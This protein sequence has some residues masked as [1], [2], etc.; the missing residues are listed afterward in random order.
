MFWWVGGYCS[1]RLV[2][3]VKPAIENYRRQLCL[4]FQR[5]IKLLLFSV[6]N[7][8]QHDESD[9]QKGNHTSYRKRQ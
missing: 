9:D 5:F 8:P 4:L 3:R 1:K 7:C 6:P 2:L